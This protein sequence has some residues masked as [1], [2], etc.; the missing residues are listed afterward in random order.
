[1]LFKFW[2]YFFWKKI[3]FHDKFSMMSVANIM[4]MTH[5]SSKY[6]IGCPIW[7]LNTGDLQ[8]CCG[9]KFSQNLNLI[10]QL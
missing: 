10:S 5:F 2:F 1:M 8:L 7:M 4:K 6:V 3:V 9:F